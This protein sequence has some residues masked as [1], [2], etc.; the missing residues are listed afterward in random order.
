MTPG[1]PKKRSET[2]E[3]MSKVMGFYSSLYKHR[4]TKIQA[5]G[6]L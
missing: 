3:I 2:S 4:S 5:R 6:L 1:K